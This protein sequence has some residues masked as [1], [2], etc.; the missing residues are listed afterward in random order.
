[1]SETATELTVLATVAT[2][3]AKAEASGTILANVRL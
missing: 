3:T 1:L 2:V